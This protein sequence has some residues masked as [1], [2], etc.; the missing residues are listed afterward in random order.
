ME[1]T[2]DCER[3][4]G[5]G[6]VEVELGDNFHTWRDCPVCDGYGSV[7]VDDEEE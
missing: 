2:V 6:D 5:I 4:E 3:C 7:D 1:K